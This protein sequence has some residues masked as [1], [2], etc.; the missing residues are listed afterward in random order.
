MD[1]RPRRGQLSLTHVWAAIA[2]GLPVAVTSLGKTMTMDLAYGLR[3]GADMIATH[4][5]ADVDTFTFTLGG[6]PW[7]NQQWVSQVVLAG[8]FDG[9]G[10]FGLAVARAALLAVSLGF[11]FGACRAQGASARL[12]AMLTVAGWL[13]GIELVG[14]LRAQQLGVALFALC[15]WCVTTR[16]HRWRLWFVPVATVVWANVHG[17]FPLALVLLLFAWLADR[18]TEPGRARSVLAAMGLTALATIATPWGLRS[19][20]YVV[21]LATHPVV[22]KLVAEWARPTPGTL[23]GLLFFASLAAMVAVLVRAGRPIPWIPLLELA[24]F[25]VLGL[26]TIRGIV[27]WAL[28]A[29]VLAAGVLSRA[30]AVSEEPAER[31]WAYTALVA[32]IVIGSLAVLPAASRTDGTG[33][34]TMLAFAP[35]DLV[36]AAREVAPEDSR[37]FVSQL[38]ASWSEF[39]APGFPVA[40]DSR[41]ELFPDDVWDDYF[42]VTTAGPGWQAVLD[43]WDVDLLILDPGQSERLIEAVSDDAAWRA[44]VVRDDGAVFVRAR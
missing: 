35:E 17:S 42:T 2:I 27:W 23:T 44:V 1:A 36:Q 39:S 28:A 33:T 34:P 38:Y 18:S 25:A 4:H 40:V 12:S 37:A 26:L 11:V 19:W 8:V 22:S 13:V 10:W 3:A 30:R 21:D 6:Q 7:L 43:E 16:N 5:L 15:L 20:S 41:I 14:Q 24:V 31:S 32:A 29:P 9:W